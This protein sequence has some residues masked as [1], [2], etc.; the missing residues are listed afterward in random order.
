[1]G[2][3]DWSGGGFAVDYLYSFQ[4]FLFLLIGE[5]A[6]IDILLGLMLEDCM[7]ECF[8]QYCEIYIS[9]V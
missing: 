4:L 6:G 8:V 3:D 1:M 9:P 7:N 2:Y 5:I